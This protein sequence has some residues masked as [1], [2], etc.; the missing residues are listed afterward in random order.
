[1]DTPKAEFKSCL[2][3]GVI[4]LLFGVSIVSG[5]YY[6]SDE[7]KKNQQKENPQ[8]ILKHSSQVKKAIYWMPQKDR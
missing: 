8:K 7:M 3:T 2:M 6:L 4:G 5:V 1:M